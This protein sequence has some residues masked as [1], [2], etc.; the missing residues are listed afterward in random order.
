MLENTRIQY[1]GDK[2]REFIIGVGIEVGVKMVI[3]P[4]LCLIAFNILRIDNVEVV[5]V[6]DGVGSVANTDDVK[7]VIFML[8]DI[9]SNII[10]LMAMVAVGVWCLDIGVKGVRAF[11]NVA[12]NKSFIELDKQGLKIN[13]Y[14]GS[15]FGDC[16]KNE[17]IKYSDIKHMYYRIIGTKEESDGIRN[18]SEL[19]IVHSNGE[20]K[21]LNTDIGSLNM[22]DL[23]T[24]VI[25]FGGI[26]P[27]YM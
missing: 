1:T 14:I 26:E 5:K 20:F 7:H 18:I 16:A 4:L 27:E 15:Y 25:E 21:V 8:R 2:Q 6:A 13:N 22:N 10:Y 12:M 23:M 3:I 11:A 24:A 19:S 9:L 17:E